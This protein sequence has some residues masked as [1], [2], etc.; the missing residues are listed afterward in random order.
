MSNFTVP[1]RGE[2][3]E[4]NQAIF[5]NLESALGMVPNL[6]AAMA[7]SETALEN[8][9]AFQNSKT[10]F[11]KKEKEVVNLVVSQ[12]NDCDYCL[13]AH[14]M[15]GEMN[16]FTSEQILELRAGKASWDIKINALAKLSS[17]IAQRKGINVA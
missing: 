3:S 6:Y 7:H 4:N 8:Y 13:A 17:A 14:T 10:S 2:V 5:N 1:N 9:L 15:M 16:G 12:I 11:S